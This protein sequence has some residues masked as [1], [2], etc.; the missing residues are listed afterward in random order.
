MDQNSKVSP[1]L[2]RQT[3]ALWGPCYKKDLTDDEAL[4]ILNNA[5]NLVQN[6][7]ILNEKYSNPMLSE[8]YRIR[9]KLNKTL[10]ENFPNQDFNY[11]IE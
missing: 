2:I 1:G 6:M 11:E 8:L 10:K 4:E 5:V 9:V 3:K 7:S